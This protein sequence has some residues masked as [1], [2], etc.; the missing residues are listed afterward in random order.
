MSRPSADDE[1]RVV[2]REPGPVDGLGHDARRTAGRGQDHVRHE[3]PGLAG[4]HDQD[5][6][7][8]NSQFG[9]Q[10]ALATTCS[11]GYL[12]ASR[13][14]LKPDRDQRR[15]HERLPDPEL[16]L[17]SRVD[18]QD[19]AARRPATR[20]APA[21]GSGTAGWPSAACCSSGRRG[22]R[23]RDPRSGATMTEYVGKRHGC[24]VHPLDH[25]R[26]VHA[27]Q[28]VHVDQRHVDLR[29][30][31]R[32]AARSPGR[33]PGRCARSSRSGAPAPS[34]IA[35]AQATSCRGPAAARG[36]PVTPLIEVHGDLVRV[37]AQDLLD[38]RRSPR[39]P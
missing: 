12:M 18:H 31:R 5:G 15:H 33:S 19:E 38:G 14:R 11:L 8:D 39:G 10:P 30:A 28:P 1:V 16:G 35:S 7:G 22:C 6:H 13:R 25:Q 36:L 37:P 2:Q 3:E 32:A 9:P 20:P 26:A 4:E 17:G 21:R 24:P 27:A 23:T 34:R 29:G